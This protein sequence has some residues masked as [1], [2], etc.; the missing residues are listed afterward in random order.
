MDNIK[1]WTE[2]RLVFDDTPL[3]EVI[4]M[5]ERWHGVSFVVNDNNILSKTI[6]G[7]FKTESIYQI[8]HII[9]LCASVDYEINDTTVTLR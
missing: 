9:K 4:K 3:P 6:T 1:A 2:G 8:M 5:L 7:T